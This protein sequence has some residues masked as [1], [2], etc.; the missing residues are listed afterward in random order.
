MDDYEYG[1]TGGAYMSMPYHNS[2]AV[3]FSMTAPNM[4]T[5][6]VKESYTTNVLREP[7]YNAYASYGRRTRPASAPVRAYTTLPWRQSSHISPREKYTSDSQR[8]MSS[9]SDLVRR[10][11]YAPRTRESFSGSAAGSPMLDYGK[12]IGIPNYNSIC[13]PH[14]TEYFQRK[15]GAPRPPSGIRPRSPRGKQYSYAGRGNKSP[16]GA[17][18]KKGDVLYKVAV[19]TGDKKN[20]GTSA[21]VYLRLK[22]TKGKIPKTR[23]TKKA[24]SV[25]KTKAV[26][27]R[28]NKGTTHIFKIK[29]ADIGDLKSLSIEHDGLTKE[30]SWFLQEIEVVNTANKKAWLFPCSQWLSLFESDC[31]LSRELYPRRHT[32]TEY[33][34]VT[35]TGDCKGA[36]TDAHVYI[37]IYGK[38]GVTPKLQLKN[39][40]KDCFERSQ[41]DIFH[42]KTS[43][44]GPME[45][46]RI[47]HDN[48][49]RAPGWFLDRVVVTDQ[50]HPK[51]KYFFPCNQWLAKD[52]G[53]GLI[54]RDL[55]GSKDPM[56]IRKA[57]K[58]R[59]TVFTADRRGAGTDANVYM[60]LFGESGDTGERKLD[61]SNNNFERGQKDEFLIESPNLGPL[62]RLRVGHDNKGFSAGWYL[63]K[64]IVDD[65]DQSKVYE[66]PCDRWLA[67]DEDDGQISR[68][69][70]VG[71]G[72]HDP[73]PGIPYQIHVTTGDVRHAGTSA[74]VYVEM[75]GGKGGNETS[76]KIWLENGKFERGRTDIFNVEVLSL[77]SPLSKLVIGHD[78]SGSG[79]GWF[80]E[81]VIV[82]CP[83]SGYE[84]H[85]LCGKW[86]ADDE[87]DGVIERTL[88]EHESL[89]KKK[90]KKDTWFARIY[91]SDIRGAG[92]DANVYMVLYGDKGKSDEVKLDNET[93][94]FEQGQV[95]KFKIELDEVGKPYKMRIRHDGKGSFAGWHLNKVELENMQTKKKYVFNCDQWLA[96]DEGDGEIIREMPAEGEDI[97]KPMPLV[98]YNVEVHTG[99]KFGAGTDSNVFINLFGEFGDTGERPLKK[100]KA[101]MNKFERG[102]VDEFIVKA[103]TLKKLSKIRIGHD[104]SQAGDGWFLDKV[105]VKQEGSDKY[106]TVFECNRWLASDED[107]GQI[108]REITA[109]GSQ[110]L[111][112]T[113]YHIHTKT[114]DVRG[115]GTDANVFI[116]I[117]GAKNKTGKLQLKTSENYKNKFERAKTDVFK[118]ETTYV[119]KIERIRI[120]HDG[121]G[122]GA[123]WFLDGVNIDVPS[124]GEHYEFSCHRW[125]AED[126]EDG[127]I[128]IE[129]EPTETRKGDS[130]IPYEVTIWTGDVRGAGTDANVFMQMYGETGK[131]EEYKLDNK[132]N[133]F[134][135]G[136][137]E[138][139]KIEAADIGPLVKIRI[140]H[141]GAGAFAGWFLDK[142]L[143][144]RTPAKTSKRNKKLAEKAKT[145]KKVK[146]KD[147]NKDEEE[148]DEQKDDV[149]DETEDYWFLCNRWFAKGEDDGQI[150]RELMA[151]DE[152]GKP[153]HDMEEIEY[154]V[155]VHTGDIMGA[156]TDAN[157]FIN[158][159][160]EKGDTGER[161]LKDS[162]N[163]NKFER[164]VTDEFI[165]KAIDLGKLKKVKIRHDNKG[166]GAAWF[167]DSVEVE[168]VKSKRSYYFPCQ[169]WLA[170]DEDDGQIARDLVPVDKKLM[171]LNRKGSFAV[172]QEIALETK[173]AMTTYHVIVVTGNVWGAGTDANV[174]VVLY[175]EKDDTGQMFLKVSK[176]NKDK[177]ERGKTD[178][179]VIEAVDIGELKKI[180]IGHDNAGGGGAWFLERVEIDAPSLGRKWYFQCGR[181]LALDEDDGQIERELYPQELATEAYEACVPYEITTYTSDMRGGSTDADVYVVLYGKDSC[182]QQKSL[183]SSKRE[184]K[185]SFNKGAVDKFVL[186]LED[187]GDTIEKIRIGH[188][189]SGFGSGWHL[190]KVEVRRLKDTGKG[191][192]T[193]VFPCNRWL[194]R[195]EDDG[196]IARELVAEKII[197]ENVKKDGTVKKKELDTGEKLKNKKYI[198]NVYTGDVRGAG[199]DANVFI[200]IFGDKGDSGERKLLHS[201]T[202]RDKFERKQVDKFIL[203]IVDLG[204]VFKMK[205]RHDNA[206]L[207]AD[208]YLDKV[209]VIDQDENETYTFHCERWLAK[210]KDDG[211]LE[212]SLYVKGY[213]G[214][215]SSMA[216]MSRF[217]SIGSLDSVKSTDPFSKSPRLSRRQSAILENVPEGPT[218]PYTI[219]VTTGD[220]DDNGTSSNVFIKIMGAK[221]GLHTGQLP[222]ELVQKE[223][224]MPGSIETFSVEAVDVEEVKK[225]EIGH[226][227][228]TPGTGWFLKEVDVD[229]PTKGKH[230][231][232][233]CKQWLARDKGDGKTSRVFS[234]QDGESS[235]VSYK[236]MIP[237]ELTVYTGDMQGAGTD[238][239]VSITVFGSTGTTP[240]IILEKNGER[241]ERGKVDLIKLE[242]DEIGAI[243][244]LRIGHDGKGSRSDWFLE[245]VEL[246]NMDTG[247][248]TVFKCNDW[249]SKNKGD[250]KISRDL[251]ATVRGKQQIKK[252]NY[253]INV[254]TSDVKGAGTDANVYIILFG[255]NGDSGE[256]HLK[257]SETYKD[258]F[259]NN[260]I[261][262]FTFSDLLSLGELMKCRVW[263]DNKGFG[264]AWHLDYIE[265]EDLGSK[266]KYI[267]PCGRWLSTKEDDKQIIRELSCSSPSTPGSKKKQNTYEIT[268][269]TSDKKD[270][271]TTQ[272]AWLILEGEDKKKS[273]EFLMENSAKNK[274]L[275][276]GQTDEFKMTSKN[277]GKLKRCY[278]G[279]VEREDKPLQDAQGREAMWHCHEVVVTDTASGS[280]YVFPCKS[281]V[282]IENEIDIDSAKILELKTMEEGKV[283]VVRSLANVK[284]KIIVK[285]GDEWGAGT[286]ANV[287]MTLYG[288]NG[289]TGKRQLDQKFRDLFER[290]QTDEFEIEV[291]DLGELTKMRIEHDNSGFRP[292][293]LLEKVE[294]I[295]Q[296]TNKSTIFPCNKWFDKK[297]G[298]GELSRDLLPASDS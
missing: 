141:D 179:F 222:L 165:V 31:Q 30:D 22:G 201:E 278:L 166:G 177:F 297:K 125:L 119:G 84:Q 123:G 28:F 134:E 46:I 194:A 111:A 8:Y 233:N 21:K 291:L 136:M 276:R 196:A 93:D 173:A 65:L 74:R 268:V 11:P 245:K 42:V 275:R 145:K 208:W 260:Q 77:L 282:K 295:N 238:S 161:A 224:F 126:E 281:W 280:K 3:R 50:K 209:E 16:R 217:G 128:E 207:M 75:F 254:K 113:T 258:P 15:F 66:F 180:K 235:M 76:G 151:T 277:L 44:V 215:M 296:A 73:T 139:F 211:K 246:R 223:K 219:K 221:K 252:T 101:N 170:T 138:K 183:C 214:D 230:Y 97:K 132:T 105:V 55:M 1:G 68:E 85:F 43:C 149:V 112:T 9:P 203:E 29:G 4:A 61:N 95:D 104:G 49:G 35:V 67:K 40:S 204:K 242:L 45:K 20:A 102:N 218:I 108:V 52:E 286:N 157:V 279:A 228:V 259:E 263:H 137:I 250:G 158:I 69:L 266:K 13:D 27:F 185:Q 251:A 83:L 239:K 210:G 146:R 285:T 94:N 17:K 47:E 124:Y 255:E 225:I 57:N 197:E 18:A 205:I 12:T 236:P 176:T 200:T 62:K 48:L 142:V 23:L 99:K 248:L 199:T 33:E 164:N 88:Y 153:L 106:D 89:R 284:Y 192:V 114:G 6:Y 172:R 227:G 38:S 247:D 198:V 92:T 154:K 270:G 237:C 162:Q 274:I 59:I 155:K 253:K 122:V 78:N 96:E 63:D 240:E 36:G 257:T 168:D 120:G 64:I 190:S 51:W 79:A 2:E 152:Q 256:L 294:V 14:L 156:G 147:K 140:G 181:C 121:Q 167:L 273:K 60:T 144:Q 231:Y 188:D 127:Q 269:T 243:K 261:D 72:P 37:T 133:N 171:G 26:S 71:V 58:Y 232:F 267:F 289:D 81:K 193:Y 241:F 283:S 150:V 56:A 32:K 110:M 80:L 213:D 234:L 5:F 34:I 86:F 264:A 187:V 87:D 298:D 54:A 24:G 178:E 262:I 163:I 90:K 82:I 107:D 220:G 25:K 143:I 288:T 292:A 159:S 226:D 131:T 189:N 202:N 195:D 41:S 98:T 115:A 117:Y 216:T 160:G 174:Y 186:E 169:R 100:S 182:T 206:N 293:W 271:G 229:M 244:K 109:G 91:T 70:L 148:D 212:R 249:L 129:L 7:N 53:D 10:A 175:G 272:N 265:V 118:L 290:N 116:W 39:N 135:Q 103:V 130:L 191:S 287:F 184:R 19:T